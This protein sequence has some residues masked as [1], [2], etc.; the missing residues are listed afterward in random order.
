MK[1]LTYVVL[2]VAMAA[3]GFGVY[4]VAGALKPNPARVVK[5]SSTT[6]EALPGTMYIA[7][8]GAIYRF[9]D[10]SFKQ[11]TDGAGWTEPAVSPDGSRLVAVRRFF[12]Y[13]DLYLLSSS[14]RV[15]RQLTHHSSSQVE[16][17]HWAFYPAFSA[18]GSSVFYSY[19]D[20]DP[21]ASYRVDLSIFAIAA[22]GSSAVVQW[23]TPNDYTGG[24]ANPTPLH[25]GGIVYTKYS[26][27]VNS[28]VHSQV[29]IV[30]RRGLAGTA[31]TPPEDNC[32]QPAL[33]PDESM[34]AMVCRH[35]DLQSTQL[36]VTRLDATAMT[37]GPETVLVGGQLASAPAFSPD[38][39]SIVF[40][41]PVQTG[42]AFQLWTVPASASGASP[43]A[44]RP[45]T[46]NLGLDNS[47]APA[48]TK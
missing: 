13:S 29:W 4:R 5:P 20:K 19:D 41:A 47:A 15:L 21:Y 33:S 44:A 27:D 40:L 45:I 7:Q 37:I 11:I 23:T 17:N 22:D 42:E 25:D 39:K 14:G 46:Q 18:D 16:A 26:I 3:F 6:A 10:G 35:N 38:G 12:N 36:V 30:K 34:L 32:S 31:L 48:W 2:L 8:Q 1:A 9:K 24:D 28:Q 43:S